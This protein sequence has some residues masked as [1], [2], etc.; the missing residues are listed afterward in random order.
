MNE[1]LYL[2]TGN[3][4]RSLFAEAYTKTNYEEVA[5]FSRG[6]EASKNV[7]DEVKEEMQSRKLWSQASEPQQLENEDLENAELAVCMTT[8]H[9]NIIQ[10]E[11][12]ADVKTTVLGVAD[13]S[14][15]LASEKLA[16]KISITFDRIENQIEC[17]V[18][19]NKNLS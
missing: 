4:F 8:H 6:T 10:D 2:C 17:E 19:S 11:Y 9:E 14:P 5:A 16:S 1:V 18:M 15:D 7:L 3:R 13:V 12:K